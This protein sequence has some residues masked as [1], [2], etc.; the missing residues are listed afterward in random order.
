MFGYL[1]VFMIC[2]LVMTLPENM[3]NDGQSIHYKN[4]D[5]FDMDLNVSQGKTV[6][7]DSF[8]AEEEVQSRNAHP[9]SVRDYRNKFDS[10]FSMQIDAKGV[11]AVLCASTVC[12][13]SVIDRGTGQAI[14]A[15]GDEPRFTRFDHTGL[16]KS[17]HLLKTASEKETPD[18][19]DIKKSQEVQSLRLTVAKQAATINSLRITNAR[20]EQKIKQAITAL[21]HEPDIEEVQS[22]IKEHAVEHDESL[23]ISSV[24]K[25]ER[26]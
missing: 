23:K 11:S 26:D 10:S 19:E 20:L 24:V 13:Y 18:L 21:G 3:A 4:G 5:S 7:F 12:K 9:P 6:I 16:A 15:L 2:Q 25:D 1:T 22:P 14:T 8:S 17:H